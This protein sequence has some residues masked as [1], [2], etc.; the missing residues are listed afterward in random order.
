MGKEGDADADI[1]K[2]VAESMDDEL[3]SPPLHLHLATPLSSRSSLL[4][5]EDLPN[6]VRLSAFIL[7]YLAPEL[8]KIGLSLSLARLRE[9]AVT[10][11]RCVS[12][13]SLQSSYTSCASP[14]RGF[15]KDN[16]VQ[17]NRS[18]AL[19]CDAPPALL[20][21]FKTYAN[22]G[23]W[24]QWFS[25]PLSSNSSPPG[26]GG[27]VEEEDF[28]EGPEHSPDPLIPLRDEDFDQQHIDI[29]SLLATFKPPM[30]IEGNINSEGAGVCDDNSEKNTT[31]SPEKNT[32]TVC[33]SK[34]ASPDLITF[35]A[36][37]GS[38]LL[39]WFDT[40]A[41]ALFA[42]PLL[43]AL[44]ALRFGDYGPYFFSGRGEVAVA[45][46]PHSP[47]KHGSHKGSQKGS[48][49]ARQRLSPHVSASALDVAD[50]A[51]WNEE[52]LEHKASALDGIL[53]E[54]LPKYVCHTMTANDFF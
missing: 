6:P 20:T 18:G 48:F 35:M 27:L 26:A 13:C 9:S 11:D 24:K 45:D 5:R 53:R 51:A 31:L 44:R 21:M 30:Q 10:I 4:M 22:S 47:Y 17:A 39:D 25:L 34:Q 38:L 1:R 37:Q 29:E 50:Q 12:L 54:H 2:T 14:M 52:E 15:L 28:P 36:C 33:S 19:V 42:P 16:H 43:T 8:G 46:I 3:L 40:R 49:K 32:D 7:L 23:K 41:D